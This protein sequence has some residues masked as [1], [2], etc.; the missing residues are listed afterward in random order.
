MGVE[1]VDSFGSLRTKY[2]DGKS[3]DINLK[4]TYSTESQVATDLPSFLKAFSHDQRVH[5]CFIKVATSKVAPVEY[6]APNGCADEVVRN[7]P[8]LGIRSYI[9][10]IVKSKLFTQVIR[11]QL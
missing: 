10:G 4:M 6:V 3:I 1:Y 11:G 5:S 2:S 8:N 9:K 7:N